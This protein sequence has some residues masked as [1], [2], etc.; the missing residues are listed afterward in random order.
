MLPDI[1]GRLYGARYLRELETELAPMRWDYCVEAKL[2]GEECKEYIL[3]TMPGRDITNHPFPHLSLTIE[4]ASEARAT[5]IA[6]KDVYDVG[7]PLT[8]EG[9]VD[10]DLDKGIIRFPFPWEASDGNTYTIPDVLCTGLGGQAC[11]NRVMKMM[12]DR[13]IPKVNKHGNCFSCRLTQVPLIPRLNEENGL[14]HYISHSYNLATQTC[15][16]KHLT[17][18]DV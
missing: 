8:I 14:A 17:L 3:D 5:E 9:E 11:C 12:D 13:G 15:E 1:K 7:I 6:D 2:T 10:C 4:Q 16:R 18:A